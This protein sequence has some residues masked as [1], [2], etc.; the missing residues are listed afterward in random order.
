MRN[1]VVRA[2][3]LERAHALEVF[4]FE[5]DRRA[6]AL[7]RRAGRK[8][9]RAVRDA[10]DTRGGVDHIIVSR[11]GKRLHR[12]KSAQLVARTVIVPASTM[13]WKARRQRRP[14]L[15]RQKLRT[16][17]NGAA[18][19]QA[20]AAPSWRNDFN[21]NPPDASRTMHDGRPVNDASN[22]GRSSRGHSSRDDNKDD[23][24][25]RRSNH[26]P[27]RAAH[28][29]LAAAHTLPA[30]AHKPRAALRTQGTPEC[31]CRRRSTHAP[32]RRRSAPRRVRR[33]Q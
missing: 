15:L 12:R 1:R 7:V 20:R 33:R 28:S 5:K 22:P 32:R 3:K 29:R 25:S 10:V 18:W 26:P 23:H 11:N 24:S 21:R 9:R 19:L 6:S 14:F 2:A 16:S 4:A 31:R 8:N 27:P 17:K 30:A 13:F